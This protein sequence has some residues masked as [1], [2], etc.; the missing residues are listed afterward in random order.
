[1]LD[2]L[3]ISPQLLPEVLPS[4]TPTGRISAEA[5]LATGLSSDTLVITGSYDHVAGAIGSGNIREGIIS[6]TTGASMAMVV[7]TDDPVLNLALN[8]PCQCHAVPG[9]YFLLPYGQ[10]AGMGLNP[11][12]MKKSAAN[13]LLGKETIKMVSHSTKVNGLD[14]IPANKEMSTV[15]N[16]LHV[17][18]QHEY[19]LKNSLKNNPPPYDYIIIDCPP[20][21]EPL[22]ATALTASNLAI[23]P[24]QCEYFA[25]QAL[26]NLFTF[27]SHIRANHNPALHYRLLVTMFDKRGNLHANVLEKLQEHYSSALFETK[28]GFD[29]Q[30]QYSQI[31]G[32]PVIEFAPQTRATQQY[33]ALAK[34]IASYVNK[35]APR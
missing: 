25:L 15:A 5:A 16:L 26:K 12:E 33:L 2:F 9:K 35:K 4:G 30:L 29:S 23:V 18:A 7:T 10:T 21:L 19:L 1:M 8:L 13:V 17:R 34:E 3:D 32:S 14:I 31:A 11:A 20:A 22:T 27:I 6:E 24:V 28:I